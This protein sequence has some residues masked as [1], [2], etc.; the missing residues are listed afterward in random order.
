MKIAIN[1]I[2]ILSILLSVFLLFG[3]DSGRFSKKQ[4]LGCK[5]EI[6]DS[7][8]LNGRAVD[9]SVKQ[10]DLEISMTPISDDKR[11]RLERLGLLNLMGG[12]SIRLFNT[13]GVRLFTNSYEGCFFDDEALF[14]DP[15]INLPDNKELDHAF[16]YYDKK[17]EIIIRSQYM[18]ET[19]SGFKQYVIG[20]CKKS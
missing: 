17:N 6:K 14:C 16:I 4:S 12:P 1:Q 3:C 7:I 18:D 10:F 9:I 8:Y 13:A 11:E 20:H 2:R 15:K 5:A 19:G